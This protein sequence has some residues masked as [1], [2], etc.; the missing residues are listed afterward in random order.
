MTGNVKLRTTNILEIYVHAAFADRGE[1]NGICPAKENE[2]MEYAA[3]TPKTSRQA[4]PHNDRN[5]RAV[6]DIAISLENVSNVILL[7]KCRKRMK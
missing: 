6:V 1:E 4:M 7:I 3:A 5:R 2:M